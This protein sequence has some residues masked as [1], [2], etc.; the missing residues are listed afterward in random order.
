MIQLDLFARR[1]Q[2]RPRARR[3]D[4][5]T[6]QTAADR[7]ERSGSAA[8]QRERIL[9]YVRDNPGRTS[10]EIADALRLNRHTPARRLP[11]LRALGLVASGDPRTCSVQG[12]RAMVWRATPRARETLPHDGGS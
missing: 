3:S 7:A 11:E 12:T 6:S 8:S 9:A 1:P 5:E 2:T 4:P 10:A